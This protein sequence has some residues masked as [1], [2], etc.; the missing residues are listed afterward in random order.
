M[1]NRLFE[2]VDSNDANAVRATFLELVA[3]EWSHFDQV[4]LL[5]SSLALT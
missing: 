1:A 5:F 4:W 2:Q 3:H